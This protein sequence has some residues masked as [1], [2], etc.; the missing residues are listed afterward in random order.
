M[1]VKFNERL[2]ELIKQQGLTQKE[3][4]K[5]AGITEA[6]VSHYIKG[7]RVPRASVL[8]KIA[9]VL[10]TTPD[11]LM[12]VKHVYTSDEIA[13]AQRLIARNVHQMT[14]DQKMDIIKVLMSDD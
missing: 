14:K 6:A 4:A 2:A 11:D 7:D 3:L 10:K 1:P 9:N 5:Q 13:Y 8:L 12:G